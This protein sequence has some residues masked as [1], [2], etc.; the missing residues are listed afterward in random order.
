MKSNLILMM[1]EGGSNKWIVQ[2]MRST[3]SAWIVHMTGLKRDTTAFLIMKNIMKIG[4][5]GS[6]KW[7]QVK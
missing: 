1:M 2:A 4:D 5:G 6:I 7:R 3:V